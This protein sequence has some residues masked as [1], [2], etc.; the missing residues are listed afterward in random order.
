MDLWVSLL[1]PAARRSAPPRMGDGD[2]SSPSKSDALWDP[3]HD[4]TLQEAVDDLEASGVPALNT[5]AHENA[6]ASAFF[7]GAHPS[8]ES[9]GWDH[10]KTWDSA[11]GASPGGTTRKQGSAPLASGKEAAT[12]E[13]A[14]GELSLALRKAA[15]AEA[16]SA[17][18][19]EAARAIDGAP[20]A[21][22]G[23]DDATPLPEK[24]DF[25]ASL[26][27]YIGV[28]FAQQCTFE[29]FLGDADWHLNL[30]VGAVTFGEL[31]TFSVQLLGSVSESQNTWLWAWANQSPGILPAATAHANELRGAVALPEFQRPV[32]SLSEATGHELAMTVS[33]LAGGIP[34]FRG[35]FPGG[36]VYFLVTGLPFG[37]PPDPASLPELVADLLVAFPKVNARLAVEGLLE[38]I[39]IAVTRDGDR[40]SARSATG[41]LEFEFDGEALVRSGY[42]RST[43]TRS[44]PMAALAL[45]KKPA[46]E[47]NSARKQ[48]TPLVLP[49]TETE[50]DARDAEQAALRTAEEAVAALTG[51]QQAVPPPA[52]SET[53]EEDLDFSGVSDLV[54]DV[55]ISQDFEPEPE[56]PRAA[57][58]PARPVPQQQPDEFAFPEPLRA[59]ASN[60]NVVAQVQA[61]TASGEARRASGSG[62]HAAA[63]SG[64]SAAQEAQLGSSDGFGA[65]PP[66]EF[67]SSDGFGAMPP[68]E[69][70]SAYSAMTRDEIVSGGHGTPGDEVE[71]SGAYGA[72]GTE[73][74]RMEM[75]DRGDSVIDPNSSAADFKYAGT[76]SSLGDAV[77]PAHAEFAS[78]ADFGPANDPRANQPVGTGSRPRP[79]PITIDTSDESS[80]LQGLIEPLVVGRPSASGF[81]T[82]APAVAATPE[83]VAPIEPRTPTP[84]VGLEASGGMPA[85]TAPGSER[86]APGK[87]VARPTIGGGLQLATGIHQ[88]IVPQ[89][90]ADSG[91]LPVFAPNEGE[92]SP[93]EQR[94]A[95]LRDRFPALAQSGG[96]PVTGADSARDADPAMSDA[97]SSPGIRQQFGSAAQQLATEPRAEPAAPGDTAEAAPPIWEQKAK[98]A[99][100]ELA[101]ELDL[102]RTRPVSGQKPASP[103]RPSPA[104][105]KVETKPERD[106][107]RVYTV[108]IGAMGVALLLILISSLG[109]SGADADFQTVQ[110]T[111]EAG[112][113]AA[114]SYA[115]VFDDL[116]DNPGDVLVRLESDAFASPVVIPWNVVSD[117]PPAVSTLYA[118]VA[119]IDS[120][121]QEEVVSR[122][123]SVRIAIEVDG[124]SIA[125]ERLDIRELYSFP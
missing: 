11:L 61:L 27:R 99:I 60:A 12:V 28:A 121:L 73:V 117:Q 6:D 39:G 123:A 107:S 26:S 116:P 67:A 76:T 3:S 118:S 17:A 20:S 53:L 80:D 14:G 33:G 78:T 95:S 88:A 50:V 69:P 57:P 35:P 40:V 112:H 7:S 63:D 58:A 115:F 32:V 114:I 109:G 122:D 18:A 37:G 49:S 22:T 30:D 56:P 108:G 54:A 90:A 81:G 96:S 75:M 104:I 119:S 29:Q 71:T 74:P 91:G 16:A 41:V 85:I 101:P 120:V 93:A 70:E 125:S 43:G 36:A 84:P 89:S 111:H 48:P 42:R 86:A 65:V 25:A 4:V 82:P 24:S 97:L 72:V 106:L 8:A 45:T 64:A 47:V 52:R 23:S 44:A 105:A 38:D 59:E 79:A 21:G 66:E 62:P 5:T 103:S 77:A 51:S 87:S 9:R 34:Y 15:A 98:V 110:L 1:T 124:H 13:M 68:E 92:T 102:K 2:A 94:A 100:Q 19:R 83:A 31:G 113:N 10:S 46:S 55:E